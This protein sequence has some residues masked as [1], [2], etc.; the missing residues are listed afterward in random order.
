M[1]TMNKTSKTKRRSMFALILMLSVVCIS[2]IGLVSA[3]ATIT[4]SSGTVMVG[5]PQPFTVTGLN[6]SRTYTVNVDGSA[7]Q[8]GLAPSSEGKLSIQVTFTSEGNHVVTITDDDNSDTVVA[9][10]S[11][12]AQDIV[13]LIIVFLGAVFI[14]ILVLR[15]FRKVTTII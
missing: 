6:A 15:I 4:P 13:N 11:M 8:A 14:I 9:T 12:Y 2:G 7:S 5:L 1:N 3:T 10:A